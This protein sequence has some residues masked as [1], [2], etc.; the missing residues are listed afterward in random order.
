MF[1]S[2]STKCIHVRRL[3]LT[4]HDPGGVMRYAAERAAVHVKQHIANV[5]GVSLCFSQH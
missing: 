2:P 1:L 5:V 4:A 3:S